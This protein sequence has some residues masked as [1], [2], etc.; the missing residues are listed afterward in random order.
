MV[1]MARLKREDRERQIVDGAIKFFAERGFSG[2]TRELARGLGITQPLLYRYFPSKQ[3]LIDRVHDELFL[4]R[5]N[6][7]WENLVGDRS[8]ELPERIRL[9]YTEFCDAIFSREWVRMF[10]YSGLNHVGYNRQVLANIEKRILRRLCVE[11]RVACGY[12]EVGPEELTPAELEYVWELHGIAFY[13]HVRK[14]VYDLPLQSSLADLVANMA[15][16]FVIGGSEVLARIVG[17][18][19]DAD[20]VRKPTACGRT[21]LTSGKHAKMID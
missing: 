7:H 1:A 9:F 12:A 19:A 6:P 5:W 17:E 10:V 11:L 2:Q 20:A 18:A 14:H 21:A 4:R 15:T 8:L 16:M 3:A 13:Y